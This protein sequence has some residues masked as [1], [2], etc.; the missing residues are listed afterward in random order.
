MVFSSAI[1]LFVFLP[2]VCGLYFIIKNLQIRN[3][4]L[5]V[6]SLIFYGFGE[7]VYVFLM[8]GS[9]IINYL[10]GLLISFLEH[11]QF[12]IRKRFIL[13]LAVILNIGILCVFKY[14]AFILENVNYIGN[15]NIKIPTI[16]LP[17][18]ISFF[19]FQALSYVIDVYRDDSLVQKNLFNLMLYI[20]FFPQLIAGP[21]IRYNEIEKQIKNRTTNV[22]KIAEGISRFIRGLSKKLIIANGT[23]LIADKIF[24][25]D[26]SGYGFIVGWLGAIAYTLQIYYDFSGYSDM[27][28]GMAKIFGFEFNE[29]FCH[30]YEATGI[31]DFWRRW[32]ISLSLW[33]REYVY[34]PLGGNRKGKVRCE[35]NKLIVF[36]LTGLWHGANWTFI[37]WG[38]IHGVANVFEDT[39]GKVIKIKNKVISNIL[40][41]IVVISAFV[42][43]RADNVSYGLKMLKNM[44]TAFNV[45]INS[46][47]YVLQLLSPYY[48]FILILAILFS[49][50]LREGFENKIIAKIGNEKA[51]VICYVA[52]IVLLVLCIMN[53]ATATYNPFIYFRF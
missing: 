21:I 28:I 46:I 32:H 49:Y 23:G 27:A 13:V 18:G 34:I 29:N 12:L 47:S 42:M 26:I 16:I 22:D 40:T 30:P 7:P 5:I 43:F 6:A 15:I 37:I 4:L 19:S 1:F 44:F 45:N 53:L 24:A 51:E 11:R 3:G 10:L 36:F 38:M 25:L 48:A 35:I 17:I 9:I 8:I 50:S 31:K 20:S 14:T 2:I 41:W 33:F 52:D 39:V